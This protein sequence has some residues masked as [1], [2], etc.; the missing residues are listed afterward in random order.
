MS[1]MGRYIEK[2]QGKGQMGRQTLRDLSR[3]LRYKA[4]VLDRR[5]IKCVLFPEYSKGARI[6]A[7]HTVP[8]GTWK[9]TTEFSYTVPAEGAIP[10]ELNIGFIAD[11]EMGARNQQ[12]LYIYKVDKGLFS[13]YPFLVMNGRGVT[14]ALN[15]TTGANAD[16]AVTQSSLD[17]AAMDPTSLYTR[18]RLVGASISFIPVTVKNALAEFNLAQTDDFDLSIKNNEDAASGG[19]TAP[20]VEYLTSPLNIV[21]KLVDIKPEGPFYSFSAATAENPGPGAALGTGSSLADVFA[22]N[23]TNITNIPAAL[24]GVNMSWAPDFNLINEV[25]KGGFFARLFG[26]GR[27]RYMDKDD[28][29]QGHISE[30]TRMQLELISDNANIINAIM[31]LNFAMRIP[32][33]D[34][35]VV[36]SAAY[37]ALKTKSASLWLGRIQQ[38][39]NSSDIFVLCKGIIQSMFPILTIPR[40]R[41]RRNMSKVK[42]QECPYQIVSPLGMGTRMIYLPRSAKSLAFRD[43]EEVLS[44][45]KKDIFWGCT[46]G[47]MSGDQFKMI[48]TRHFE[49]VC[50]P[51]IGGYLS[52]ERTTPDAK[53]L[54]TIDRIATLAPD[55][56]TVPPHL[57]EETYRRVKDTLGYLVI[58]DNPVESKTDGQLRQQL[59]YDRDQGSAIQN[60]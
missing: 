20:L 27:H 43:I 5:Y 58:G 21:Q 8:T 48:L 60:I 14:I 2:L 7:P 49:G 34:A 19:T 41:N 18:Y 54:E 47:L 42:I 15:P 10:A 13:S 46:T 28:I 52:I 56:I 25:D 24:I 51:S 37:Q 22:S 39:V 32:V 50:N 12:C 30:T 29:K 4:D 6:P 17:F 44:D 40:E 36:N 31:A 1:L 9:I 38:F 45:Q 53:T 57:V 59:N 3:V 16:A 55:L 35:H 33:A 23:V 11:L 26:F